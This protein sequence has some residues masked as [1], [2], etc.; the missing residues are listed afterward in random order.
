MCSDPERFSTCIFGKLTLCDF[1]GLLFACAVGSIVYGVVLL[2]LLYRRRKTFQKWKGSLW[3]TLVFSLIYSDD[4]PDGLFFRVYPDDD[5][6]A[7][8]IDQ[9]SKHVCCG[10]V[11]K[12]IFW[13]YFW[14]V[15]ILTVF[16]ILI[17]LYVLYVAAHWLFCQ[18]TLSF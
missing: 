14:F 17:I 1:Y 16:I 10:Y 18:S 8:D 4:N 13:A 2:I 6:D 9:F 11:A 7:L 12:C 15:I 5:L 3:K